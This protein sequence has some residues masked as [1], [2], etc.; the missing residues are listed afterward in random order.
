MNKWLP[1][2]LLCWAP[3]LAVS[4]T[5][6]CSNKIISEGST[7]WELSS[8]CGDPTQVEHKTIYNNVSATAPTVVA[9]TTTEVHLEMW[10][11]NFG[12]TRLMQRIWLEDGV[13]V[14]I[15]SMGYGF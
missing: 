9:G 8:L 15:E 5:L 11:Y 12:P 3:A 1:L 4:Q 13:V 6:Q 14:R 10:I 2:A 7:R